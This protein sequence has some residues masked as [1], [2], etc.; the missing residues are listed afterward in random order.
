MAEQ[1]FDF[2]GAHGSLLAGRIERPQS[3]PRGWA[4]FA[5]CFTCGKDSLAAARVARALALAGIGVLRFDFAG[6]GGSAGEFADST[7]AADVDDL[8]AAGRAMT[9]AGLAPSLLIG[10]SL[11]GAAALAAAADMPSVKA[12]ATIGAPSSVEHVLR[13]FGSDSLAQIER[14][15]EA[16]LLLAGRPFTIRKSFLDDARQQK[17]EDRIGQMSKPLLVMHAPGDSIVDIN[18]ATRIFLAARHPKSFVSL[19]DADHLLTRR[20]DS[21]YVASVIAAWAVRYLPALVEDLPDIS[22]GDGVLAEETGVGLFQ[23]SMRSGKHSFLADEPESVGGLASG[24]SPYEFVSAG[25]AACTVMTMRMYARRK[26]IPLV[27]ASTRVTHSKRA[28]QTPADLFT[29]TIAL[30]GPLNDEQREKLLSI[31]D[32]CPVDLTLVR[33]SDVSTFLEAEGERQE[34]LTA[35]GS[36]HG[37]SEKPDSI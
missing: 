33:G 7:F 2:V 14:E 31:A 25:L 10:H 11:G 24:L 30:H 18:N 19:D 4:I 6:L 26:G 21:D 32:R 16:E 22:H 12:V 36:N 3:T 8:V 13:L 9:E 28:D 5:H 1:R 23:L 20:S 29:R 37:F 27:R 35:P 34:P 15:G 17:L